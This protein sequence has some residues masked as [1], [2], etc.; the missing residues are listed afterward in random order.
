MEQAST[1]YRS[2]GFLALTVLVGVESTSDGPCV[3]KGQC[4]VGGAM[5]L[6]V[7]CVAEGA[8]TQTNRLN[9]TGYQELMTYCRDFLEPDGEFCCDESQ[10]T[11]L[12][13]QYTNMA[14]FLSQCPSC[15]FNM[16]R[17]F[18]QM[19]CSPSQKDFI[20][21]TNWTD[22]TVH[23][24]YSNK[25]V[26]RIT[27]F[28]DE[29]YIERTYASCK[30]V[31]NSQ[32]QAPA[33]SAICAQFPVCSPKNL[34][35]AIGTGPFGP[36]PIDFVYDA[37]PGNTLFNHNT[38]KCSAAPFPGLL[39]CGCADCPDTCPP[40]EVPG[41][42]AP[43]CILGFDGFYVV[44]AIVFIAL[45]AAFEVFWIFKSR[46][47]NFAL[48]Q[49]EAELF[50]SNSV[51]EAAK[52]PSLMKSSFQRLG[53][54]CASRPWTVIAVGAVFCILCS[55]G[56][57]HFEVITDPVE[58]WS[59]SNSV[60]RTQRDY[61]N[62]ELGPFYRIEQVIIA[63]KGGEPFIYNSN[64]TQ[65]SY[66]F[67]PVFEKNFLVDLLN[68]QEQITNLKGLYDNGTSTEEVNLEDICF[69]PLE[70]KCAIQSV[71][72]WFQNNVSLI[73]NN[74]EQY[75][76]HIVNCIDSPT[77]VQ[78]QDQLLNIGCLGEY[79]GPSFYYTALGGYE[80]KQPL[81]APAVILTF[82]V[83]NHVKA[84]DNRRAI[85]WEEQF[86][87]F[88]KNFTHPN[89]TIAFMAENSIPSELTAESYS[90][91]S[92]IVVSYLL[93]FL[94]VAVV[95]GRYKS[96]ATAF[97]HSQIVLGAMGVFLVLASVI[98]S[99][100][101]YSLLGIPSTLIIF[102]VVPFLV[103]AIG[104]DNIFILV[105]TYQRS[106]RLDGES[107]EEHVGRIMGLVGPSMLLASAS[108]VTCFFLGA[109]TSMPAVRTFALYAALALLIDVVLQMTVFVS[110]L[111][112]DIKRQESPRLDLLC[113]M[114]A[115]PE[116]DTE[117]FDDSLL[118]KFMKNVYS[119]LLNIKWYRNAVF[120]AFIAWF[121]LSASV[122]HRL[123]VGLDQEISMPQ[124]SYL[125]NYFRFLKDY[126]RVGPPVY[127]VVRDK[128][129]YSDDNN[130]NLI[131][132]FAG[133]ANYSLVNDL[134]QAARS[135]EK[136]SIAA[137]AMS[138]I[139]DFFG[140]TR[141]CC[142]ENNVT[143]AMCP[144]ENH[145]KG[146]FLCPRDSVGRPPN[147]KTHIR[148]FLA[149]IPDL[150]CGKGGHAAY[151]NAIH[152]DPNENS[153]DGIDIQATS[154]MTYHTILKNSSDY[155]KALRMG[156]YVADIIQAKVKEGYEGDK[157]DVQI[158]PYSIFYVY[159][160]QYLTIWD[161]VAF[162]LL[163]SF[164]GVLAITLLLMKFKILPTVAI[165]VTILMIV[166]DLMGVMYFANVSLNAISLVN[167]VMCVGISVE[168]CSHIV[169]AFVEDSELHPIDRAINAVKHTGS[170]VLS[171]ITCTKFIGVIVLAFA[172]SQLFVIFYFRMY[173]AI[174]LV[175]SI[176]GLV[177]L[178]V[179]LA[180]FG[181]SKCEKRSRD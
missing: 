181:G 175:G 107:L 71:P 126:L 177:F 168:F 93:M 74:P 139:D 176:H 10:V 165:G 7:P 121:C 47:G 56:N 100:G 135:A 117:P 106:A 5:Q 155:I 133:A 129:N 112:L 92:T 36:F 79:G 16:A 67:S 158:F 80:D 136:T 122:V 46:A 51:Q 163:I 21:V 63:N 179:F 64:V 98:S 140:W 138:W 114:G 143:H 73:L 38:T 86:I 87:R 108:E 144:E 69:S 72:N 101:I 149:A 3:F 45:V 82:L 156:R 151:I 94:Y 55:L 113:C 116:A 34:L 18:C 40:F 19:T 85:A 132:S 124:D 110:M 173:L 35:T 50:R 174:V 131:G 30:E 118:F 166:V 142:I 58:L 4:G 68:L 134:R 153:T 120:V 128:F 49:D 90:D 150:K 75:L 31:Q 102:E 2:L 11:L 178:P 28:M 25:Q 119:P 65:Q 127:F 23:S 104:V 22:A 81:L 57:L 99:V 84:E 105:Q 164:G 32:T 48:S 44:F 1:M 83:N 180:T 77:L 52:E 6:G 167:L 157:D 152:I 141:D 60:A 162:H 88:M 61:Y 159:Y 29:D 70:K 20:K 145:S 160:E 95:L 12:V 17:I 9:S 27:Y 39:P 171:G 169:K 15:S 148:D 24:P 154:F 42:E 170:S 97:V 78:Q 53:V 161:D 137:P 76:D 123:D 33:L 146:C 109:L 91:V 103:L 89:M 130:Q 59:A 13:A 66:E 115:N 172:K 62:N 43:F 111:T 14:L 41:D 8:S 125:Q 54:L 147:I 96:V 26:G 37:T